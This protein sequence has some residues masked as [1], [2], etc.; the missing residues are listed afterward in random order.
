MTPE[1]APRTSHTMRSA[2]GSSC[3]NARVWRHANLSRHS[4]E[5]KCTGCPLTVFR[6]V[7]LAGTKVPQ[8]GSRFNSPLIGGEGGV[9]VGPAQSTAA[10]AYRPFLA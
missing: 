3:R 2:R 6:K 9:Q 5:Q 10:G 7:V 4:A 1:I 8:T